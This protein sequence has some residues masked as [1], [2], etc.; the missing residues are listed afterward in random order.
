MGHFRQ[1]PIEGVLIEMLSAKGRSIFWYR[2][3]CGF[4]RAEH[5]PTG[6]PVLSRDCTV[7]HDSMESNRFVIVMSSVCV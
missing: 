4:G 2:M 7:V 5:C 1:F 6:V 3:E